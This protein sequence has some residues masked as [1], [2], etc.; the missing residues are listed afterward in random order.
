MAFEVRKA[1]RQRRPIKISLEGLSGSGKTFTALRLAFAMR[2]AG[3]G[4]RIVVGDSENES[5]GLYDGISIDGE[6]WEYEVCPI[7]PAKQNP[8]GYAELYEFLVSQ[9]FDIVIVDSMTHAWKGALARV[10]EV[11]A[12]NKGDKFGAGWRTVTPEQEQM[13]R[14]MTDTRAH[15]ITTT[16]VKGEYE[17]VE[18]GNGRDKIKKVGMKADQRDGAE[19]EYDCVVRLDP[20]EHA[21]HVEKVRGCTAMDARVGKAPG[22]EFWKPLFDWWLSAPE[23]EPAPDMIEVGRKILKTAYDTGNPANLAAAWNTLTPEQ[24][25]TLVQYKDQL[26][27]EL[28]AFPPPEQPSSVDD[29]PEPGS[30]EPDDTAE[31]ERKAILSEVL[32][33]CMAM[34]TTAEDEL[35]RYADPV[36]GWRDPKHIPNVED[37]TAEQLTKLLQLMR[38]AAQKKPATPKKAVAGK[39]AK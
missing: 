39:G 30:H 23:L 12:R 18:G 26:K 3:I 35:F 7:P 33:A 27:D 28:T 24:K 36:G 22:P 11:A 17:R 14:V 2:R 37:V 16:R 4:K 38:E 29:Q 5:A 13:F 10:D 34:G 32:A 31:D 19:Y 25:R 21:A 8:A 15:L 20:E 1:R 6:K 9:G